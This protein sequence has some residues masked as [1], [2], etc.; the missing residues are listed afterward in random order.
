MRASFRR[1]GCERGWLRVAGASGGRRRRGGGCGSG[2]PRPGAWGGGDDGAAHAH[3]VADWA[4]YT[5]DGTCRNPQD[6]LSPGP[7]LPLLGTRSRHAPASVRTLCSLT[8]PLLVTAPTGA[9]RGR[10]V[11][12]GYP[13][14]GCRR[15]E[16]CGED[17]RR[18]DVVTGQTR[19]GEDCRVS[20]RALLR[21]IEQWLLLPLVASLMTDVSFVACS[22]RCRASRR[23]RLRLSWRGRASPRPTARASV[24]P[25]LCSRS[26]SRRRTR[27]KSAPGALCEK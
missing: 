25:R 10:E 27:S 23:R 5:S 15:P 26:S 21:V 14:G 22:A 11:Q 2:D 9:K 18:D 6:D 17:Q 20:S 24:A 1:A 7:H 19:R 3:G 4:G 16:R 12:G 8:C 13:R